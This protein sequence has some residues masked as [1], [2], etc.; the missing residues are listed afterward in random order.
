MAVAV[1]SRAVV[2]AIVL[3]GSALVTASDRP[4][5]RART[6][7]ADQASADPDPN[8][9]EADW[10]AHDIIAELS[11]M[12]GVKRLKATAERPLTAA[13]LHM[14]DPDGYVEVAQT[15]MSPA[16]HASTG[17]VELLSALTTPRIDVLEGANVEI[18][19]RM[20]ADPLSSAAHEDAALLIGMF[21]LREAAGAFSD[22]RP[23]L[24]RMTAH[25]AMARALGGG[26][27]SRN[28][29]AATLAMQA[30]LKACA[31]RAPRL[32]LNALLSPPAA[33]R[34][35]APQHSRDQ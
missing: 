20:S 9:S 8:R 32:I 21:A 28:A 29:T 31:T 24:S 12:P 30:G 5:L 33:L 6:R 18:S 35:H 10:I 19:S 16:R 27:T 25:L 3:S 34:R 1:R 26:R 23:A 2:V 7:S 22:T 17:S 11:R 15:M 4:E 13:R 14:W